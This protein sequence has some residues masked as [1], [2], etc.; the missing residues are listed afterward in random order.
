MNCYAI[1]LFLLLFYILLIFLFGQR[2]SFANDSGVSSVP[3]AYASVSFYKP[4]T[5]DEGGGP[6]ALNSAT[7]Q[8]LVSDLR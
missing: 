3:Q 8:S 5:T 1:N 2:G 4:D 7:A 6:N